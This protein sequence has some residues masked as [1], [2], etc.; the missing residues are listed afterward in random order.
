MSVQTKPTVRIWVD[1]DACPLAIKEILF[2]TAK[3]LEIETILVANQSISIPSSDLIRRMTVRDG[4]DIA[5]NRIVELMQRHDIVI[6]G[7][8]PLA[9][10]VVDKGG[11]AIGTR[12]ELYD[13][14]SVHGRLAS[15]NLMEQ[16]RAA[17]METTGPKPLSNR[18]IQAFANQLDRI[19]TRMIKK[20]AKA[21]P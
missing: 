18:D 7:D 17:G 6:T 8:I 2:R 1:A 9:S 16:F 13:D 12:G 10:R 20:S 19:L 14:A 5:D 4:A 21:R 3:R 11:V 15:R